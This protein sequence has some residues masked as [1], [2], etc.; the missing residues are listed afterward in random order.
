MHLGRAIWTLD[1]VQTLADGGL[2][3]AR[4]RGMADAIRARLGHPETA[5]AREW[6]GRSLLELGRI[7]LEAR[8][9]W[10]GGLSRSGVVA[11]AFN[12]VRSGPHGYLATSD[13]PSLLATV[14][15][16]QLTAGYA[17]APRT[18]TPWCC[19]GTLPDFRVTNKVSV[20]LGPR[21]LKVAEHS[22]Y[23]RGPLPSTVA[24]AQLA[25]Y[26]RVPAFTAKRWSTTTSGSSTRFRP[27]SGTRRPRWSPVSST[28]S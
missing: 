24:T 1:D 7:C 16:T 5:A 26:G 25:K 3:P 4:R 22:E 2:S 28:A 17:A 18:F 6:R 14:G 11:A 19:A 8:G 15:R 23:P 9:M 12:L 13:F 27:S 10:L 20:G 21:L